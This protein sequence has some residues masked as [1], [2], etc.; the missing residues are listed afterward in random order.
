MENQAEPVGCH[1]SQRL[2]SKKLTGAVV[3]SREN[4][5]QKA[6]SCMDKGTENLDQSK[7]G[8]SPAESHRVRNQAELQH[9]EVMWEGVHKWLWSP[10]SDHLMVSV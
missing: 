2:S 3:T 10:P 6:R 1:V 9:Q 5:E 8:K 7:E 4:P